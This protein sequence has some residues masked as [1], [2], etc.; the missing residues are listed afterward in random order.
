[1][2]HSDDYSNVSNVGILEP[3]DYT[4]EQLRRNLLVVIYH[5]YIIYSVCRLCKAIL[6]IN[7]FHRLR[8]WAI[9]KHYSGLIVIITTFPETRRTQHQ[10]F[11]RKQSVIIVYLTFRRHSAS[12]FDTSVICLHDS[13]NKKYLKYIECHQSCN[14]SRTSAGYKIVDHSVVGAVASKLHLYSRLNTCLQWI[15]QRNLQ[16]ETANI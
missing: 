12:I 10:L 8:I 4:A 3:L 15:D 7:E 6:I 14:I 2:F 5:L 16:D 11:Y 13:P 9:A 1:M